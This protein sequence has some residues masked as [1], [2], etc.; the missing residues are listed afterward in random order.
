[1]VISELRRNCYKRVIEFNIAHK[2]E[3]EEGKKEIE[4]ANAGWEIL[5]DK[6]MN[7]LKKKKSEDVDCGIKI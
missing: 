5:S 4:K 6:E 7:D 1:M 3:I 2:E